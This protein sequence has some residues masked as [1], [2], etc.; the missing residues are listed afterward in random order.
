MTM[1]L[2]AM[3]L[4]W[5]LLRLRSWWEIAVIV[6]LL[7]LWGIFLTCKEKLRKYRTRGWPTTPG[8]VGNLQIRKVD[9]GM[10]GVDYWKVAFD[11]TY[12]VHTEH[13][14]KYSFNCVTEKMA[15]GAVTGLRDKA[16]SVHYKPSD[17]SKGI[18]WEDEVWDL[19]WDTYWQAGKS[20][21]A[22]TSQ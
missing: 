17:E 12:H 9:G 10:N 16:V 19:W 21:N 13:S 11:Y 22:A 1:L 6:G 7:A 8:E 18:V 2:T 15:E 5:I 14:G 3:S 4:P 20:A